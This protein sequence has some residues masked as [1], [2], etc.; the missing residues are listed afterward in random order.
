MI[1]LKTDIKR[2]VFTWQ[3][4]AGGIGLA[5]AAF[6]GV[7]EKILPLFQGEYADGLDKGYT[8]SLI[9]SGLSSDI[10]LLVLPILC[11]IPYTAAFLDD[12]NNKFYRAYLPRAGREKY[13]NARVI[14]TALSGGLVLVLGVIL[15]ALILGIVFLPS[16]VAEELPKMSGHAPPIENNISNS[17]IAQK[18]FM[19]LVVVAFTYFLNGVVWALVG[20]LLCV[21][22][23]SKY[24]AYASP[25]VLYYVL[26]MLTERYFKKV[27]VLNPMEWVMPTGDWVLGR[28]G[29]SLFLLELVV[30]LAFL[31]GSVM[32]QRLKDV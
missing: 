19:G 25:F 24:V 31:Y 28:W 22:T 2:A 26:V 12:Y 27:Y 16:E 21:I 32:N 1:C 4:C 30:I 14:S 23:K 10:V 7:F 8:I 29:M 11:T 3:F 13:V 5:V 15:I 20:S 6:F 17:L 18:N 9:F